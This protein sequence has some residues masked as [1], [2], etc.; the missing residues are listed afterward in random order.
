[1]SPRQPGEHRFG[2]RFLE[3]AAVVI[4]AVAT[5]GSAWCA[6][7]ASKWNQEQQRWSQ[8]SSDARVEASRLFALATQKVT[9]DS[10]TVAMYA[11]AV[12]TGNDNLA[13]FYKETLVRPDFRD[14]LDEWEA[15]VAEG[16]TPPN[17][18][19]DQEYLTA[20][21]GPYDDAVQDA[22]E[23]SIKADEASATASDYVLSTL[24][25]A[26]A[27]FFA[28]VTTSFRIRLVRLGLIVVA[29][30]TLIYAA[31]RISDLGVL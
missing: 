27:L 6:Y 1:V 12:S 25:V 28:G 20:V 13:R 8:V 3:I 9:Y 4:L 22:E 2:F 31:T 7:E 24:I 29:S 19:E 23:A 16:E 15:K 17:L 14:K 10:N 11:E 26:V 30:M 5:V 21:L 18:L